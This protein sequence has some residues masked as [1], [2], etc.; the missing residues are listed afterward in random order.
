M[1]EPLTIYGHTPHQHELAEPLMRR[2]AHKAARRWA[3]QGDVADWAAMSNAIRFAI[4][5]F[6][7]RASRQ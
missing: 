7:W 4:A 2:R 6:I 5:D 3:M 1:T